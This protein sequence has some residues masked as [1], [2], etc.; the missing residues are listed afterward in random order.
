MKRIKLFFYL[1]LCISVF[2]LLSNSIKVSADMGPKPASYVTIKGIEGDYVAC[3]AGKDATGPNFDYDYWLMYDTGVEYNSIMK[4]SDEDGFKW[5][6][7]YF[8]CS[9][10][11]E[12]SF[13]YYC[14]SEYKIVIYQ[15]DEFLIATDVLEMYAFTTYYEIDFSKGIS[16]SQNDIQVI[17]TYDYFKEI[18]NLVIRVVLTLLIEIGLFFLFKLYTK[19]NLRIV[20]IVNLVTQIFLNV[21]V[22]IELFYSGFLL[23]LILLFVLEFFI[24]IIESV[25]YQAL[26]KEKKH[27]LILIYSILANVLS[28]V[29]GLIIF[30]FI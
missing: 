2:F 8:K 16:A 17:N 27:W 19:R 1:L 24:L 10:T 9:G 13:T 4:Y 22:N 5:M 14:P 3:F 11:Q 7:T 15:N 21:M 30:N 23:A 26:F 28:F 12:I 25:L 6:T 18:L 29:C 20:L